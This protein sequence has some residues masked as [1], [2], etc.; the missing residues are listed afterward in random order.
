M[1]KKKNK[2]NKPKEK[3]IYV[4][5]G[6]T[7]VDMSATK[8]SANAPKSA[9]SGANN[10]YSNGGYNP[11]GNTFKDKAKTYFMA[12]KRMLVP[13]FVTMGGIT[14]IFLII[15]LILDIASRAA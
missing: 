6:S 10:G 3:I 1:S 13:M 7:V 15:Y 4:D 2:N 12:V 5:D 8:K 11:S 14:I 9:N